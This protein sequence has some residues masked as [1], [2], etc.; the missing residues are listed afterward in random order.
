M[1][2]YPNQASQIGISK[3]HSRTRQQK[4]KQNKKINN[5]VQCLELKLNGPGCL[6]TGRRKRRRE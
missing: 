5:L 6:I 1:D 2:A 3:I 4:N